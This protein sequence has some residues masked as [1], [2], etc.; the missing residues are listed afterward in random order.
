ML[1]KQFLGHYTELLTL[2]F[3]EQQKAILIAD[4]VGTKTDWCLIIND[5]CYFFSTESYHPT[6]LDQTSKVELLEFWKQLTQKL[7]ISCHFYG[8]GCSSLE[9]QAKINVHFTQNTS[10]KHFEVASDLVAAGIALL[11]NDAGY[12]GILGTGSVLT[13]YQ[14]KQITEIIGGYGY[15]LGDEGSGY[16]FG[17]LVLQKYL[18]K[19]LSEG[20]TALFEVHF[21]Q[22]A[23]ISQNCYSPDGKA[24]IS[25]ILLH[26]ENESIQQEINLIHKENIDLFLSKYLPKNSTK[27]EI[28]F[29]GSY[30]FY[31]QEIL[32]IALEKVG[33][34]LGVVIPKP[35]EALVMR[36]S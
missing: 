20:L 13:Y 5:Q 1:N 9:N 31:Q 33:W 35:I 25:S 7:R 36:H 29:V 4:S 19:E 23:A 27:K 15:L 34:K 17:K 3:N 26:S 6:S 14:N 16:Y 12:V 10:F 22:R 30:A 28:S 32:K 8:A 21:G 11:G 24:F 2:P 18:N